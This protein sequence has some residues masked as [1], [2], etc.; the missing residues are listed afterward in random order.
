MTWQLSLAYGEVVDVN[1]FNDND[2]AGAAYATWI[3]VASSRLVHSE[4]RVSLDVSFELVKRS[5][6]ADVICKDLAEQTVIAE[7]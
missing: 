3:R 5:R 7:A 2:N 1:D 4:C 6:S